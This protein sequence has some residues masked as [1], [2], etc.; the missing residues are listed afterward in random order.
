M[1]I[2]SRHKSLLLFSPRG[3][4]AKAVCLLMLAVP[5]GYLNAQEK[6]DEKP[7][8]DAAKE[9]EPNRDAAK[10]RK[11][12]RDQEQAQQPDGKSPG[13]PGMGLGK[14]GPMAMMRF[15][16]IM[17]ALDTDHDGELSATEI[18]NASKSLKSLDRDGNGT[19]SPD[20]LRPDPSKMMGNVPPAI[21][22]RMQEMMKENGPNGKGPGAKGGDG[23]KGKFKEND[24]DGSGVKPKKPE[25]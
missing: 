9:N 23:G 5:F 10:E 3:L 12:K 6:S 24:R 15:S 16:P 25:A 11:K 22:E 8:N 1:K 20:E 2:P 18:E 17:M 14:G 13:R 21:R 4:I 7:S 19:L